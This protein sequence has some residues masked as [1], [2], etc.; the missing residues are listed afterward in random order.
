MVH[1]K[2]RHHPFLF[3]ITRKTVTKFDVN[4]T[5]SRFKGMDKSNTH[6]GNFTILSFGIY[7][8]LNLP[9]CA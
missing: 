1:F 3:N 6:L 8:T 4:K 7:L 9:F 5:V 2:S